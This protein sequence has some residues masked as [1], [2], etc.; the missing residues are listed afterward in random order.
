MTLKMILLELG[1]KQMI[2]VTLIAHA[3]N[4]IKKNVLARFRFVQV[5]GNGIKHSHYQ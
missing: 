3:R 5:K 4:I 2:S 1:S